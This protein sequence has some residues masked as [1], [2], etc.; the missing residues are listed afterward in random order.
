MFTSRQFL[1]CLVI[2]FRKLNPVRTASINF[3]MLVYFAAEYSTKG[4]I[5]GVVCTLLI[6]VVADHAQP[7]R[8]ASTWDFGCG[9]NF[10]LDE[11]KGFEVPNQSTR[12]PYHT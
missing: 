11:K 3:Y 12:T 4:I 2:R 9:A 8:L 7:K 6:I 5:L 10:S 1:D